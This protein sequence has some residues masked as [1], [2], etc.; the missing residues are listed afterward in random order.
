MESVSR[1]S[2][3]SSLW[4][5]RVRT[6]PDRSTS[7]IV[8]IS[9]GRSLAVFAPVSS[10]KHHFHHL[11][12]NDPISTAPQD[13]EAAIERT[14]LNNQRATSKRI[15]YGRAIPALKRIAESILRE[16]IEPDA[17]LRWMMGGSRSRGNGGMRNGA[18]CYVGDN[19]VGWVTAR[20]GDGG[21]SSWSGGS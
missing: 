11:S 13:L 2:M 10:V 15:I 17:E 5:S 9:P 12:S 14:E 21:G 3:S 7:T 16:V 4:I 18:G 20:E 8:A 19:V 1:R 6:I